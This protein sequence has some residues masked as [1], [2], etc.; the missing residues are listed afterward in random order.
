MQML[1]CFMQIV[2]LGSVSGARTIVGPAPAPPALTAAPGGGSVLRV[3]HKRFYIDLGSNQRGAF[4]RIT[5]VC[6]G[7]QLSVELFIYEWQPSECPLN[8]DIALPDA[9]RCWPGA[10]GQAPMFRRIFC[11]QAPF[12][13]P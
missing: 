1:A 7:S 8:S 10:H 5:E 12:L 4:L 9:S 2:T 3:G 6:R 13:M 11:L